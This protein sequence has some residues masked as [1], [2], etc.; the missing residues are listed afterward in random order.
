LDWG[1]AKISGRA[2]RLAARNASLLAGACALLVAAPPVSAAGAATAPHLSFWVSPN[3]RDRATGARSAPFRT[4]VRARDAVR[5]TRRAH[6][7]G[8][9]SVYLLG[10]IYR[11]SQPLVLDAQDSGRPGNDV[12]WLAAPG[13]RPVISGAIRVTGL[14]LHDQ[15]RGIY[16]AR[17]P[18][19]LA[20]RELYVDG[21]RAVRARSAMFPNG[22]VRTAAGYIAPDAAMA[23]WP[24]AG[25]LEAVTLTQWKMMRCPVA[26][27]RGRQLIMRQPCWHNVSVF[28]R[29][30]S[31][32]TVTWLENAYELLDSPGEWYLDRAAGRLYYIP[33]PGERLAQADVE[34]PVAQSLIDVRGSLRHPVSNIDF[35]R[36][37][38]EFGTWLGPSGPDGYA[39]D[40]SGFHLVG[41]GHPRNTTGH[42]PDS[43]PTPGNVRLAY[44]R[45]VG[46]V[47]DDFL[48]MGAVGLDYGAGSQHD[49]VLGDR[50]DDISSA[51][52]QFGGVSRAD[53]HPSR[54]G[55]VIRDNV[56]ADNLIT[57]TGREYQD[58]AGIM[59]GFTT[60]SVV[61]HNDISNTPWSGIAI[62]WGWGLLDPGS[63][64]GLPGATAGKWGRYSKLTSSRGNLIA[65][66]RIHSFAQVLWDG[67]AI[68]T[69]GRQGSDL[70]HGELISGN[71][72]FGKRPAAGANVI[73]TDGGSRY[74]T[75]RGNALI[76]NPPG[77]TDFGPCGLTDSLSLC[78]LRIPYG[79]D[80][81]GCR[82][83]GD[84]SYRDN[85]WQ[86]PSPFFYFLACK[87][88]P[89]PVR[90]TDAGNHVVTGAAQVPRSILDAAGLQPEYRRSVGAG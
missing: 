75:V 87:Y 85:Y 37:R 72:A 4:L 82:P 12:V 55:A 10:G 90:V 35:E 68:Y 60:R 50:F 24:D 89:Y 63:F 44:A 49:V 20:S 21:R 8:R 83:Y 13:A 41:Y 30:W 40:Q 52:I 19:G 80:R 45:D 77:V 62:G 71:V 9:I 39:A 76:D 88:M 73:Y 43:V 46:F 26:A 2:R 25:G 56:I 74:V 1:K 42:D 23:G 54:A 65:D 28:P 17:V 81:G 84:L 36:I 29:Q 64:L 67:G 66:N 5:N 3:G 18:A 38:F 86:H 53:A 61:V 22:F 34:L 16:E 59:I 33:R 27:I 7:R 57:R 32:Q 70:A 51:A 11:L 6:P 79:S 48:H 31:F 58:S 69:V 78:A 14:T 47:H 15:A